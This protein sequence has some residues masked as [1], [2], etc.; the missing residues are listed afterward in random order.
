MKARLNACAV[1]SLSVLSIA[2]VSY[3]QQ[4][5][6]FVTHPSNDRVDAYDAGFGFTA[7][8][9]TVN[10]LGYQVYSDDTY[11]ST[12]S[13]EL[14]ESHEVGLYLY[15]GGDYGT[16]T[17]ETS[18]TIAA[19]SSGD[20]NGIAWVSIPAY[21]L[22]A[23][24]T[25]YVIAANNVDGWSNSTDVLNSSFGTLTASG[26]YTGAYSATLPS[27]EPYYGYASGGGA[28][29]GGGDIGYAVPEPSSLAL[30]GITAFGLLRRRRSA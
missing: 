21:T 16:Y 7:A 29:Y 3:A 10:E 22:T 6:P 19:G 28:Q 30:V 17:L 18:A 9:A 5:T 1:S 20:S 14:A 12:T 27:S 8:T 26:V 4:V 25:Y 2:A 13:G 24:D 11:A 15:S 23:G